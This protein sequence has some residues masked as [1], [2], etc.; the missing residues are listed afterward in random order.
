MYQTQHRIAKRSRKRRQQNKVKK[1]NTKLRN[2]VIF[3]KPIENPMSKVDVK[4][5]TTR[6]QYIKWSFRST[7]ETIFWQGNKNK[8]RKV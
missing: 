2:I 6:K 1:Q 8:K 7:S 5:V 3:N 4:I